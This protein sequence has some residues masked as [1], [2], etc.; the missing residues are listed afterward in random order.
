MD[1][2]GR[3]NSKKGS[4]GVAD[5]Q[6]TKV[7]TKKRLKELLT[8]HVLDLDSDPYVFRN[9]LGLLE[10]RLCLTTHLGESSYISHL[11]GRKHQMNL[12]KRKIL[13]EKQNAKLRARN[14]HNDSATISLTNIPKRSWSKIGRP[15]FKTT[16]IRDP[17]TLQVGLLFEVEAPQITVEEPFFRIMSYYELSTKNQNIAVSFLSRDADE[18]TDSNSFQYLVFSAEPYENIAFAIPNREIDKPDQPGAMTSSYWWFW[19]NDIRVFFL[20]FLYK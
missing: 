7:H 9:H 12:E 2:S 20:Q 17:S 3:V 19:D 8:T 1:Y 18:E 10:C 13:D 5:V 15:K 11:G 16:K 4:G 6:E 14:Q